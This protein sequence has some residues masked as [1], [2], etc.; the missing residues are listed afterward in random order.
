MDISVQIKK[1]RKEK[2]FSQHEVADKLS[3][4]RM[5]C[6][7]IG[8]GKS[9]SAKNILQRISNVLGSTAFL[10]GYSIFYTHGF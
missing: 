1:I 3:M 10:M 7:C 8:P 9:D 6:N 4:D 5:Q 2:G